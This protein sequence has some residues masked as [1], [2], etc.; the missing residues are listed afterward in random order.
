MIRLPRGWRLGVFC[1]ERWYRPRSW[2]RYWR[3]RV[4]RPSRSFGP[5]LLWKRRECDIA[6][7][8]D[9]GLGRVVWVYGCRT[10]QTVWIK[11]NCPQE[12]R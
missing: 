7:G 12:E 1:G 3:H 4:E 8:M 9:P 11:G 2:R 10:H 5:I 6:L